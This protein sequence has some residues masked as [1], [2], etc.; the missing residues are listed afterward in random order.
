MKLAILPPTAALNYFWTARA[1]LR[2]LHLSGWSRW[3]VSFCFSSSLDLLW[4]LS[5]TFMMAQSSDN[6]VW[7]TQ[8]KDSKQ[9]LAE[10]KWDDCMACR[11]TGTCSRALKTPDNWPELANIVN[12]FCCVHRSRS[13]Q[14]PH[15]H[16]QPPQTREDHYAKS[17]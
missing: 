2:R 16:E 6:R 7:D 11:V 8:Q 13:L 4:S 14:L 5:F 1:S 9:A 15:R 3:S 12:R 10:D 17:N